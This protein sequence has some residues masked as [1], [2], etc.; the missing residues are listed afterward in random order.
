MLQ[1]AS[2]GSAEQYLRALSKTGAKELP[3]RCCSD[4]TRA[5]FS[6]LSRPFTSWHREAKAQPLETPGRPSL[7]V[8]LL[9]PHQKHRDRGTAHGA[10]SHATHQ[11][12]A[13]P[14][15]TTRAECDQIHLVRLGVLGD[16]H[17]RGFFHDY[18]LD[19]DTPFPSMACSYLALYPIDM[20]PAQTGQLLAVQECLG[21]CSC[22]CFDQGSQ[23]PR[24]A[25]DIQDIH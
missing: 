16:C 20:A 17:M 22:D 3:K 23:A 18:D 1:S 5:A 10:V 6:T 4:A 12:A 19:L 7:A 14:G 9:Q 8:L 2:Q 13:Q 25:H 21:I 24:C 15:A 11:P